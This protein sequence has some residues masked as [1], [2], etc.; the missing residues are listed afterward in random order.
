MAERDPLRSEG[1]PAALGY[2]ILEAS[3]LA[4][5]TVGGLIATE[6]KS[7]VHELCSVEIRVFFFG[8]AET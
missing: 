1:D 5:S 4:R 6:Q 3:A 7:V 2:S 8:L